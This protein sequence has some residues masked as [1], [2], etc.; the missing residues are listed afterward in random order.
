MNGWSGN[1]PN[2]VANIAGFRK[3]FR[4]CPNFL[5]SR[6]PIT[7]SVITILCLC[8]ER[9]AVPALSPLEVAHVL[10]MGEDYGEIFTRY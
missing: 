7:I 2:R 3:P 10:L 8:S 1:E 9:A 5:H 4:L 6:V